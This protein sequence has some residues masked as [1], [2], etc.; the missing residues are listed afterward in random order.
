MILPSLSQK[1]TDDNLLQKQANEFNDF[2]FYYFPFKPEK[3]KKKKITNKNLCVVKSFQ[4]SLFSRC[5]CLVKHLVSIPNCLSFSNKM[6]H[7]HEPNGSNLHSGS[8]T[9]LFLSFYFCDNGK[10]ACVSS[11]HFVSSA[12]AFLI[13]CQRVIS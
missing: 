2:Q 12:K 5:I 6:Y 3:K 10:Q 9:C 4:Y 11:I 7:L 1:F 13:R 8:P